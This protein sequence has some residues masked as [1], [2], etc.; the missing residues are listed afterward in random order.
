VEIHEHDEG[1]YLQRFP[2]CLA[3]STE[4][5]AAALA[6]YREHIPGFDVPIVGDMVMFEDGCV[7]WLVSPDGTWPV[8]AEDALVFAAPR[9]PTGI[10]AAVSAPSTP[11][12][13]PSS[14]RA[15]KPRAR[16]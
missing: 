16:P 6:D 5:R 4:E 15:R 7:W 1:P 8:T 11:T 3:P 2:E 12:T 9:A 14:P 10:A 13:A